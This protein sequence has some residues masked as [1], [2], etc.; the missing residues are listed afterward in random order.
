MLGGPMHKEVELITEAGLP[1]RA[2]LRPGAAADRAVLVGSWMPTLELGPASWLDRGWPWETFGTS[3]LHLDLNSEWLVLADEVEPGAIGELFGVLVTTGPVTA[4]QAGL[5]ELLK[6]DGELIWV[7]YIAIAPSLRSDCPS[8]LRRKPRLKIVGSQIMKAAIAR[9]EELGL[10]GRIGLHA[11][12]DDARKT[13]TD[14]SPKGWNMR[15][16]GDA[17]HRAGGA[18]PVCF[19][20]AAWA[21]EFCSRPGAGGRK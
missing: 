6:I 17:P 2:R 13:Y 16:L 8:P 11:E 10:S 9:S 21:A 15:N 4:Q 18:F 5:Q 12:G 14:P 1:Y 3:E 7:E 20:D 19:G